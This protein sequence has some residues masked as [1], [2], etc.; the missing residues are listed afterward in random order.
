[1]KSETSTLEAT[2]PNHG[3]SNLFLSAN[4]LGKSPSAAAANGTWPLSSAKPLSAPRVETMP[5]KPT[6]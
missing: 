4:R 2:M 5:A 3:A 1:M 6:T